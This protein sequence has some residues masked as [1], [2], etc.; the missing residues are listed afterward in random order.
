MG[1]KTTV[2]IGFFVLIAVA[3]GAVFLM[4]QL[5]AQPEPPAASSSGLGGTTGVTGTGTST[6]ATGTGATETTSTGTTG[7]DTVSGTD[8]ADSGAF[9]PTGGDTG[10][11][12]P[13]TGTGAADV[14]DTVPEVEDL[15]G[16]IVNICGGDS[17]RRGIASDE[18]GTCGFCE[19]LE[20]LDGSCEA[21]LS[22]LIV[23]T[24]CNDERA[25]ECLPNQRGSEVLAEDLTGTVDINEY[26]D[27]ACVV[28]LNVYDETADPA[29]ATAEPLDY[30]TYKNDDCSEFEVL[31]DL[32]VTDGSAD[33]LD[34]PL[35]T[36][37]EVCI[38]SLDC[39]EGQ[40]CGTEGTCVLEQCALD[41]SLC[42]EADQCVLIS[43][44]TGEG[45]IPEGEEA[46]GEKLPETD[47]I[48]DEVDR[49][50]LG[51][52]VL[53]IGVVAVKTNFH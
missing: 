44:A 26:F 38:D 46:T 48:N 51:I 8:S 25:V 20:G 13:G 45:E 12:T 30:V 37:G 22:E 19:N 28:Q 6:G 49:I 42:L 23:V 50:L 10:T 14:T 34:D 17:D 16:V 40:V 21:G 35:L 9:A 32:S 5:L 31:D 36:C 47:L 3:L 53:V 52:L 43:S 39:A 18:L 24:G 1:N 15:G 29:S 11:N 27:Q 4:M 2:L 7:T 41:P 33:I